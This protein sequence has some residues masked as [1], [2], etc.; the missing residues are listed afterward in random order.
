M[1]ELL[2]LFAIFGWLL[3]T[4]FEFLYSLAAFPTIAAAVL[5]VPIGAVWGGG[6]LLRRLGLEFL[7]TSRG[8]LPPERFFW[9]GQ[10]SLLW[11]LTWVSGVVALISWPVAIAFPATFDFGFASVAGWVSGLIAVLATTAA[12]AGLWVF[13]KGSQRFDRLTPSLVGAL[14]RLMFR[15]SDNYEFLGEEPEVARKATKRSV[16]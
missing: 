1:V 11:R 7:R 15:L 10:A 3:I 16:Y 14:R 4:L 2:I 8:F 9:P 6:E 5:I 12:V 13:L